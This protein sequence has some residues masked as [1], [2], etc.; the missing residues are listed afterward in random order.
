MNNTN[1]KTKVDAC[2][3]TLTQ[4]VDFM[5]KKLVEML[6]ACGLEEVHCKE[7]RRSI[8]ASCDLTTFDM[9]EWLKKQTEQ[10]R[11]NIN[12]LMDIIENLTDFCQ[13]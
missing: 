10:D 13:W 4:A 7:V 11:F 12:K 9:D 1:D 5:V 6:S 8:F 2:D 3:E